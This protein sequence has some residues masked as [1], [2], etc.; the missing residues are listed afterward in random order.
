MC[1][2]RITCVIASILDQ[3]RR[4]LAAIFPTSGGPTSAGAPQYDDMTLIVAF[5]G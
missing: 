1:Q 3:L 4:H 5:M 2:R